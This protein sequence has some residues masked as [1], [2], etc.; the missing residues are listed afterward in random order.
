MALPLAS[1]WALGEWIVWVKDSGYGQQV[2]DPLDVAPL[3]GDMP[4]HLLEVRMFGH[5]SQASKTS[6][7]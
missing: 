5:S 4:A 2:N 7:L 6:L 3:F 1:G